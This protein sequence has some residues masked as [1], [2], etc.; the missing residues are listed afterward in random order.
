MYWV[1]SVAAII[2]AALLFWPVRV[3]IGFSCEPD[4]VL[5]TIRFARFLLYSLD[6]PGTRREDSVS[7]SVS[8]GAPTVSAM[9]RTG[10]DKLAP[11]PMP[12]SSVGPPS[13]SVSPELL[14]GAP[15]SAPTSHSEKSASKETADVPP[16]ISKESKE[17]RW[18]QAILTPGEDRRLLRS[19]WAMGRRFLR[20]FRFRIHQLEVRGRFADPYWNGIVMGLAGKYFFPDWETKLGWKTRGDFSIAVSGWRVL[21][22]MLASISQL[23][24]LAFLLW[25][26]YRKTATD[27]EALGLGD[28]RR[29]ILDKL[30]PIPV[31]ES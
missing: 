26:A 11:G 18:L 17:R 20:I 13:Q 7:A 22:F 21:W 28:V 25:K 2:L 3:R 12:V 19:G 9:P 31:K 6:Y 8:H 30:S 10:E 15:E 5:L 16:V 29:W 4:S 23:L 24:L 27:P 1:L 14:A